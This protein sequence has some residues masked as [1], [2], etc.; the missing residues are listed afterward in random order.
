MYDLIII[1]GGAAGLSAAV[2]ALGKQLEF[3]AIYDDVGGKTGTRQHLFGQAEEEYLAVAEAVLSFERRI[4]REAKHSL[5]DRVVEVAKHG[6]AFHVTTQHHGVLH[7]TALIV[8]SGATPIKL[9]VPGAQELTGYG[10][11]YSATTH[12]HIV[13]GRRVAVV[14]TSVR[15]LRGAAELARTAERV[16]LVA[17]DAAGMTTPLALALLRRPNVEA[18]SGYD[19]RRVVGVTNVQEL[20]VAHEDEVRHLNV[21]A[22]FVDLGLNPNSAMVRTIAQTD[23]DGFIWVDDRNATTQPGL[24]AAGDVTT[25]FGEQLLIAIGEGARAALS[26]YDYLLA[27]PRQA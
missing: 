1:G 7:S 4:T 8:A 3:L 21:D 10:L 19:V 24:F 9:D 17:P 16:Y 18:L 11:G 13:E 12:A 20:I 23:M 27:L 15:A 26:A 2:Y 5:R 25:A 22:V 6:G 14:G